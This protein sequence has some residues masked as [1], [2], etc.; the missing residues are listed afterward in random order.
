ML[1]VI[2]LHYVIPLFSGPKNCPN[3]QC[4]S[5]LCR[6]TRGPDGCLKCICDSC[7]PPKC[8]AGCELQRDVAQGQCPTC[9]CPT[10][11]DQGMS[12]V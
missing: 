11:N 9:I 4:A 12:T 6:L 5:P 7:P 1:Y 8:D 10:Y 3:V 2:E